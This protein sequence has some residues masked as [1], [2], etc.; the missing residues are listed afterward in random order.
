MNLYFLILHRCKRD[1]RYYFAENLFSKR[2]FLSREVD[3]KSLTYL[4]A[5]HGAQLEI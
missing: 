4:Y 2:E 5:M 3:N 1:Q